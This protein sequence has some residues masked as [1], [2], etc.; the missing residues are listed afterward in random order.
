MAA[1]RK[2]SETGIRKEIQFADI[3]F[4]ISFCVLC[5]RTL[6]EKR[7]LVHPNDNS[8]INED[9]RRLLQLRQRAF[10]FGNDTLFKFYRNR[11]NRKRKTCKPI[12]IIRQK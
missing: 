2:E 3:E 5:T 12:I 8:W 6:H 10:V 4:H 7:L 1:T 11:V 9:L